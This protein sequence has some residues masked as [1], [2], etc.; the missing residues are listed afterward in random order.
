LTRFLIPVAASCLLTVA[1]GMLDAWVY[2]EHGHVFANAQ[3]GNVVLF[4]IKLA[5]GDTAGALRHIPSITA[6]IVGLLLSRVL[7]T[8]LKRSGVNSRTIRLSAECV[9]LVALAAVAGRLPDHAVTAC[10]G[11]IAAVQI[12]TVSH[13]GSWSFNTGMTTGNLR[14]AVSAFVKA[15]FDPRSKPDWL[16]VLALGCVC[17]AF[18]IGAVSGGFLAPSWHGMTLLAIAGLVLAATLVSLGSPDPFSLDDAGR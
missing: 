15:L 3:T 17:T 9:L 1:G 18:P 8:V 11:F 2:L 14:S 5:A 6:F 4:A 10:V 12:T 7:A 13:I 16:H